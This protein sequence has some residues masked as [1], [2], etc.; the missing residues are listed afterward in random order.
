MS[1]FPAG[2]IKELNQAG[3]VVFEEE[4]EFLET[5]VRFEEFEWRVGAVDEGAS[6]I[7]ECSAPNVS[8]S[9]AKIKKG[10]K[11]AI[12]ARPLHASTEQE[13]KEA[14]HLFHSFAACKERKCFRASRDST[15]D[16]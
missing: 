7:E 11:S 3:R 8:V 2:A 14:I 1:V 4:E 13:Y 6:V 15:F 12:P 10:A 5:A 16:T 9:H